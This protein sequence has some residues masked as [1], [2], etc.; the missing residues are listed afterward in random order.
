MAPNIFIVLPFF[1]CTDANN[2]VTVLAG[3]VEL[4]FSLEGDLCAFSVWELVVCVI[5][6]PYECRRITAWQQFSA[7][8][9]KD[10]GAPKIT[11]GMN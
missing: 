7:E 5:S 11:E 10:F 1:L 6:A 9:Y 3:F 2:Y 8:S 4:L